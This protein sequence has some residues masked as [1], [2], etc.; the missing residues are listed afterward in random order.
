M[1]DRERQLLEKVNELVGIVNRALVVTIRYVSDI[2]L[3]KVRI[4]I[5]LLDSVSGEHF[6]NEIPQYD[7]Y[8]QILVLQI[9]SN[10]DRFATSSLERNFILTEL[11]EK[12]VY[13]FCT[14]KQGEFYK[15]T[16]MQM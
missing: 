8:E 7:V 11:A 13:E 10:V 3:G 5:L 9:L 15:K 2:Q 6:R 1:N 4:G 14:H 12:L 16:V